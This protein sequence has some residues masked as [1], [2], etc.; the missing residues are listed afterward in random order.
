MFRDSDIIYKTSQSVV[1]IIY[2]L[3][4][5]S[6]G[7]VVTIIVL[8]VMMAISTSTSTSSP[9]STVYRWSFIGLNFNEFVLSLAVIYVFWSKLAMAFKFERVKSSIVD[10]D[11]HSERTFVGQDSVRMGIQ[12]NI[13]DVR[14]DWISRDKLDKF[15]YGIEDRV[16]S[17]KET[18]TVH[19]MV[20]VAM[21]S[22]ACIAWTEVL[23]I[24]LLNERLIPIDLDQ[25]ETVFAVRR[26]IEAFC[27]MMAALCVYLHFASSFA[28]YDVLC[29]C[30]HAA[31][32]RV[33]A[34]CVTGGN[35]K[36]IMGQWAN[37][38]QRDNSYVQMQRM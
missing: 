37:D 14:S 17:A 1:R 5:I 34:K 20:R 19:I 16:R 8:E 4:A 30:C 24:T 35:Q 12:T 36:Y 7:F 3:M 25:N 26:C 31:C 21:L 22:I 38:M 23:F 2:I 11:V 10:I 9:T 15:E 27:V 28:I 32:F 6:V 33:C 18:Q 29:K 13:A